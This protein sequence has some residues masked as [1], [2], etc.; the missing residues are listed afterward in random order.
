MSDKIKWGESYESI[1]KNIE[2][3]IKKSY[4]RSLTVYPMWWDK[5]ITIFNK[6]MNPD[7][8]EIIWYRTYVDGCFWSDTN[9]QGTGG[10]TVHDTS[11]II[12]RIPQDN[13]FM[14]YADW[15]NTI[16]EEQSNYFTL[17]QGD[18][19]VKGQAEDVI[20]EYQAG[21]RSSDVIAKYKGLNLCFTIDTWKDNTG[22]GR[23][24]PHYF[25]SGE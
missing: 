3:Y 11:N 10:Q 13:R 25:V 5:Q 12:L 16:S 18:I 2:P 24:A 19:V 22:V 4:Q 23:V 1:A 9:T 7:T 14:E 15:L 21:L 8:N 6:Y 20:N 17:H